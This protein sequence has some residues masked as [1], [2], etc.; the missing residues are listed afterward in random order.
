MKDGAD[1]AL[2]TLT[3][4]LVLVLIM[5][6]LPEEDTMRGPLYDSSL[7]VCALALFAWSSVVSFRLPSTPLVVVDSNLGAW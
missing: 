3:L 5:L 4:R 6:A 2:L 7:W 1:F